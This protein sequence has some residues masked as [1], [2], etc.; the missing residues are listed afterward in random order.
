MLAGYDGH[1]HL[2]PTD[3]MAPYL[4]KAT[5]QHIPRSTTKFDTKTKTHGCTHTAVSALPP[6]APLVPPTPPPGVGTRYGHRAD[7]PPKTSPRSPVVVYNPNPSNLHTNGQAGVLSVRRRPG[8][9][10][11]ALWFPHEILSRPQ[12]HAI[13]RNMEE[14]EPDLVGTARHFEIH[15]EGK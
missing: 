7:V 2:S 6:R 15:N 12:D 10:A 1:S 5:P 4:R 14:V 3:D 11:P 8:P 9:P 13:S